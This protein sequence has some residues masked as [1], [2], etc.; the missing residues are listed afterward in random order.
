LSA[1]P[2]T[3][4]TFALVVLGVVA[5]TVYGSLVP[6]EFRSRAPGEAIDSFLWAMT[7][8]PL[9]ESRSDGLANVL[10]GVPLG[11]ALLGLCR[12]DRSRMARTVAAGLVLLPA[13]LAFAAAVEFA[14]LF[15][16]VRTCAGSDVLC[17]GF[18]AAVGMLGWALV[19]QRLTD[20]VR[21]VAGSGAVVRLL[22]A[23]VVLLAFVQTL[24]MDLTISPK[25]VYKKLRDKVVY[26]PFTEFRGATAGRTWERTATLLQVT[27]LYLPVGLL[28]ANLPGRLRKHAESLPKVFAL[29]V[30]LAC[31]MEAIQLVVQ[32]RTSSATDV[33]V[34]A[35]A[36][37]LGWVIGRR[38]PTSAGGTPAVFLGLVWFAAVA[39]ICWQPFALAGQTTPFDWRPGLPREGKSDLFALE[40]MLT[41]L[42]T[43]APFGV[44]AA[45]VVPRYHQLFG[46]AA[47]LAVAAVFEAGQT[48]VPPHMPCITDVI[49]GGLGAWAG[50]WVVVRVR[51]AGEG[52]FRSDVY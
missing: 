48:F 34:G 26:V 2:P 12:V 28:A 30:G 15:V 13:C 17:Q 8:R 27:A 52:I 22:A 23:Y 24:P 14:Q 6:F 39:V 1:P 10:L 38:F 51:S 50:A 7:N 3:R 40:E 9:P 4:R 19:G 36:A 42:A 11:F 45:A 49:L 18:G 35:T 5:F 41:K 43:F 32:S 46:A 21:E 31:G 16:P 20:Q 47:G 33:A 44:L 37:T 25:E 29:S